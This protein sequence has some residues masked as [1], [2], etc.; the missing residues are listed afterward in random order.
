MIAIAFLGSTTAAW[1]QTALP[2]GPT[3]C[4]VIA[5]AD[6]VPGK[7]LALIFALVG[8]LMA[9]QGKRLYLAIGVIGALAII[10]APIVLRN[11][12]GEACHLGG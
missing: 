2:E 5:L 10:A 7:A 6:G 8:A 1:A 9:F 11:V 4:V 3:A 12:A